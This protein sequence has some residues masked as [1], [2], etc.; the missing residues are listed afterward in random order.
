MERESKNHHVSIQVTDNND[1][2]TTGST[3][4]EDNRRFIIDFSSWKT[5]LLLEYNSIIFEQRR[6][7]W[8]DHN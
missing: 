6:L 1:N 2:G 7:I 8:F 5:T 3:S 4:T